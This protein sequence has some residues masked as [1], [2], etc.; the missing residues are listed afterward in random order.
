MRSGRGKD[1]GDYICPVCDFHVTTNAVVPADV[2]LTVD[3]LQARLVSLLTSARTSGVSPQEIVG[4]LRDELAFEAEL[5]APGRRML[6]QIIDLGQFEP[7]LQPRQSSQ[8]PE[9]LHSRSLGQ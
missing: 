9:M 3:E 6:V 5:D 1:A 7:A 4:I 8:A 2:E